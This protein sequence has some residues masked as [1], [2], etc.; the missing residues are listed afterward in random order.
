MTPA[1]QT[2]AATETK[3]DRFK[4]ARFKWIKQCNRNYDLVRE[5]SGEIVGFAY[6][7][8]DRRTWN[9][10][11]WTAGFGGTERRR[12]DCKVKLIEAEKG[13]R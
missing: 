1:A 3:R 9:W 12:E 8:E 13:S 2:H 11:S 5:S 6:Y 7:D 10:H 4:Y